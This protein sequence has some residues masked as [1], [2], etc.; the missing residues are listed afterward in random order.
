[1][2]VALLI[3][4][5]CVFVW[6]WTTPLP[7]AV[8][9]QV[10]LPSGGTQSE[11]MRRWL[12]LA[13][14]IPQ[15]IPGNTWA[16][17]LLGQTVNSLSHVE[18]LHQRLPLVGAGLLIAAAGLGLGLLLIHGLRAARVL[19]RLERLVIGFGL[20]LNLLATLTLLAGRLGLLN[21]WPVRIVLGVSAA[22]G[23][24]VEWRQ[25]RGPARASGWPLSRSQTVLLLALSTPF[26]VLMALGSFQPSVDFDALEY[27]LEG[28]KEWFLQG[29]IAFLPHN[30]YTS[31]PFSIEMLHLLGMEVL[32]DWWRGA[33]AGQFV[34]MLHAPL[35]ALALILLGSRIG[36]P[37]VGL[38]AG[39][40]YL[41]TPWIYRLSLCA[42]VEGPLGYQHAAL[43]LAVERAW[44]L[45]R[46]WNGAPGESAG[47]AGHAPAVGPGTLFGVWA[48][49]G[50][51]AGGAMACKYPAL[52]SAVIPAGI[53]AVAA[54]AVSRRATAIAGCALGVVI[55]VGPWLLKNAIDHGNPVYPLGFA[56]FN[57]HP[58]SA[59]REAQWRHAHGPKAITLPELT[60]GVL[61]IAGRNDWQSPL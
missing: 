9:L 34:I 32:D 54:S 5:L 14:A 6:F 53:A 42:Y 41:S 60:T 8:N 51:L 30:V 49:V 43:L 35:A 31:M 44:L 15:F 47:I 56:V 57:G 10:T 39:L 40:V 7:N 61:E 46:R 52:I 1:V 4:E 28:P 24:A 58:W 38:V 20:G 11:P 33:L 21:P 23:L 18:Y 36:S 17:S 27:H 45:V 29:R 2:L 26:L 48:L 3:A 50:G 37:R 13:L 19:E 22:L 59:S 25:P 12:L 55:A 16:K